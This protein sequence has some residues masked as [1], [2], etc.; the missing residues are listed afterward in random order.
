MIGIDT[1]LRGLDGTFTRV[2]DVIDAPPDLRYVEGAI[3]LTIDGSV[4][5]DKDLWDDVNWLWAGIGN[6]IHDF[7]TQD[8]V[9]TYFPSQ[10]IRLSFR[11]IGGGRMVISVE[12]AQGEGRSATAQED[13]LIG[14]L[15]EHCIRFFGEMER[16]QPGELNRYA[17]VLRKLELLASPGSGYPRPG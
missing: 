5:L 1:F 4:I 6:R 9:S 13:E 17:S 14:C 11:R 3:E 7:K 16:L 10:S 12:M 8:E 2:S 15:R